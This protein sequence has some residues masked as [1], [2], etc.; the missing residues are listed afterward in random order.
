MENP[1]WPP[2]ARLAYAWAMLMF[3]RLVTCAAAAA[4]AWGAYDSRAT[5]MISASLVV[6]SVALAMLAWRL[7]GKRAD[8]DI[9]QDLSVSTLVFPPEARPKRSMSRHARSD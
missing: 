1:A 9:F 3:S 6:I 7:S 2:P 5:P 4:A 8:A